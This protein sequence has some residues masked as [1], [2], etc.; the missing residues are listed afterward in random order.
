[1]LMT[2]VI[3]NK[4]TESEVSH[5][6]GGKGYRARNYGWNFPSSRQKSQFFW[7]R[8][9]LKIY[10]YRQQFQRGGGDHRDLHDG[11]HDDR[12]DLNRQTFLQIV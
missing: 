2:K 7:K 5:Y 12:H 10:D 11:R 6:D 8:M 4:L 9:G 1:M 3:K